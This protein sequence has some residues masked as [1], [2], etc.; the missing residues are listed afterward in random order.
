MTFPAPPH[1]PETALGK[2]G[3][4]LRE[5]IRRLANCFLNRIFELTDKGS[6]RR[7][8]MLF[9]ILIALGFLISLRTSYSL[10]DWGAELSRLFTFFFVR[11]YATLAPNTLTDFFNFVLSAFFGS[12]TLRY[13]PVVIL[14]FV[15]AW[16]AAATYLDDIFELNRI[17]VA[18]DFIMQVALTGNRKSIRI[19]GG[20]VAEK[21]KESPI[22]L[23]GG[24][25]QVLVELDTVALF[26]KPDGKPRV[27]GPTVK[28]KVT[29]EGFERFRQAIDLR[30]QYPDP[31]EVDSRSL[32]GIQVSA[33][34]V[35][36]L[37]SI[38]RDGQSPSAKAPHPFSPKAVESL[39]YDQVSR[40]I[41]DGPYPSEPPVS[42]TGTSL[43]LIRGELG[44]FMNMRRLVEY[45]ASIGPNEVHQAQQRE[46]EILAVG[47]NVIA[48][49]DSLEPRQ[50]PPPPEF[51][52]R[53]KISSLFSQFTKDFTEKA[54]KRGVE[55]HWVGVGTWKTPNEIVP[56]KHLE[57]WRISRE[58]IAR[59]N[60]TAL[61]ILRQEARLQQ[62][63]RIIQ[64]APLGR[65]QQTSKDEHQHRVQDLLIAY[66]QQLIEAE[67]LLRKSKKPIHP[68]IPRAVEYIGNVLAHWIRSTNTPS[69]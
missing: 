44:G 30:D 1:V 47:N 60:P 35:R 23:I 42:W 17:D 67:E 56:S 46:N 15:L 25:G 34:D 51:Q 61:D 29:L 63:I 12:K 68:S 38:W 24:P 36:M 26:E 37:F 50:V 8:R 18:R 3:R 10:G 39:V 49:G 40:V 33:A 19:G 4:I 55:L 13:L 64:T 53:N 31:L 20:D 54:S 59:G 5:Q 7:S 58:N 66:R 57:A 21:D 22:Y 16:Q 52:A 11:D 48:D 2:E 32:D 65:F 62:I 6:K 45:L 28:G 41:V 69:S 27:I 9:I 43:S 14:P